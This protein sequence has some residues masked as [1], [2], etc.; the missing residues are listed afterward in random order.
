VLV[1][2]TALGR[3]DAVPSAVPDEGYQLAELDWEVD[4]MWRSALD[5]IKAGG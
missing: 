2:R 3:Q 1:G 4:Q 5:Q